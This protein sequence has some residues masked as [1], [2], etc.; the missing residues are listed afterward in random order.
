MNIL[1]H[2]LISFLRKEK[3]RNIPRENI[4]YV[5]VDSSLHSDIILIQLI[6]GNYSGISYSY[7]KVSVQTI[8]GKVHLKFQYQIEDAPYPHCKDS[9]ECSQDFKN[10]IGDILAELL[11]H[12]NTKIGNNNGKLD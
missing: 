9:L 1:L 6:S 8:K 2:R 4:D 10:V 7:G 11:Q 3:K 5:L 12:E